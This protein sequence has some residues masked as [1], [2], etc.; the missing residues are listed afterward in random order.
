LD[1]DDL[2]S[3]E[4]QLKEMTEKALDTLSKDKKGFFAMIEGARIDHA[5]H[6]S[7]LTSIWKETIE[8]DEAVKYCV[9]WAKKRKDTLVIVAADHE[10]MGVSATEPMDIKALKKITISPHYMASQLKKKKSGEGYTKESIKQAFRKYTNI[11]LTDREVAVF[12]E[13]ATPKK[14]QV[15]KDLHIDWEIGSIIAS[16][17]H[18][19]IVN[20]AIEQQSSTGG[21]TSNMI[22]VFAYGNGSEIFHGVMDNTDIPK[23]IAELMGYTF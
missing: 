8:F 5:S 19:G 20:R 4:P 17:Y 10:T 3:K 7:D 1:R 21:H 12:N 11:A 14:G 22:I 6:S 16:H 13:H 23:K 18:G 2:K 9:N 15:Y